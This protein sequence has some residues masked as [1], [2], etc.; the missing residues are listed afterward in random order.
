MT[1]KFGNIV[2]IGL[3]VLLLIGIIFTMYLINEGINPFSQASVAYEP[4]NIVVGNL[5]N[6]R[7]SIAFETTADDASATL[8]IS[9]DPNNITETIYDANGA[10]YTGN[11]HLFNAITLKTNTTYFYRFLINGE[12]YD[13]DGQA[14]SVNTLNL[15][16]TPFENLPVAGKFS[17]AQDNCIVYSHLYTNTATSFTSLDYTASNGT[18]VI[19]TDYFLNRVTK[20]PF[21]RDNSKLL[22]FIKCAD[23]TRG[24][25]ESTIDGEQEEITLSADF[26]Y[27]SYDSTLTGFTPTTVATTTVAA[28]T[29]VPTVT[30]TAPVTTAVITDTPI[31]T[32]IKPTTITPTEAIPDTAIGDDIRPILL[33]II[34]LLTGLYFRKAVKSNEAQI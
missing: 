33:G 20:E 2:A 34:L 32:T 18:Y 25:I 8:L 24:G 12:E 26:P 10:D 3:V 22:T 17:P 19:N 15:D 9:D 11:L 7:F 29:A 14:Y 23:G 31:Q 27:E 1:N 6:S 13:N 16:T 5:W 28:T 21:D 30:A 4:K